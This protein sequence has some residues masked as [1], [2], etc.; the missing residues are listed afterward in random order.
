[1]RK[2]SQ[3]AQL[4]FQLLHQPISRDEV[5]IAIH[6]SLRRSKFQKLKV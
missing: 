2:V 6:R 5:L 4:P 3:L 1:L